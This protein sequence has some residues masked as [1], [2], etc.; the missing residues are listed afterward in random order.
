MT[1]KFPIIDGTLLL[2][3]A[4]IN[5]NNMPGAILDTSQRL[6]DYKAAF[7]YYLENH[8][9]ISMIVFAENSGW[10]LS[11][12]QEIGKLNPY[13]KQIEYL[14][15]NINNFPREFGKGYGELNLISS[16]L[17]QSELIKK[18]GYIAKVTG[19]LIVT[20]ISQILESTS[21]PIDA[22]CDLRDHPLYEWLKLP[23]CG[24]M[25]DT[26]LIIFTPAFFEKHLKH[27]ISNHDQGGFSI[28]D[29]FYHAMKRVDDGTRVLC[30]FPIEAEYRGLAGHKNK[31]Y[32]GNKEVLKRTIRSF[33]R[34]VFPWLRI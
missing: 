18:A 13:S 21:N 7:K 32:S 6:N 19:R 27:L 12:I 8:P 16:A 26:R 23:Y 24:R 30:R 20:N 2:L 29:K 31:N 14:S 15:L 28:E 11:E 10:P 5:P 25:C 33:C 1:A 34:K 3:T 4:S 9:R 17:E 22:L